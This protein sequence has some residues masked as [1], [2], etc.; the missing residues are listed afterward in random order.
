MASPSTTVASYVFP[1][2]TPLISL[3]LEGPNYITWS[4][5]IVPI[6]K[7]HDLMGIVDGTEPCPPQFLPPASDKEEPSLNPAYSLWVKKDQFILSWI[8]ITLAESV[9]STIYGLHTSHQVWKFLATKFAS[10]SR[11][12]IAQLRRQLQTLQQGSKSCTEYVTSAQLLAHQL[13]TVGKAVDDDEL[14]TYI[15]GGLNSSFNPFVVSLSLATRDSALTFEDFHTELLSVE[16]LIENQHHSVGP[17]T[18]VALLSHKPGPTSSHRKYRPPP[19]INTTPRGYSSRFS[20]QTGLLS[21]PPRA[22][23]RPLSS[24]RPSSNQS[25]PVFR[26]PCQICGKTSHRALDCFHRMD[27][28][29]QGRHPPAHLAAMVATNSVQPDDSTWYA[30]SG[31]NHHLTPALEKLHLHEPYTGSDTIAVGN[32]SGL[33]ITNTGS[34]SFTT[35]T[36]KL[37]MSRVFHC[38]QALANLLSINQFCKDNKCFFI[39]TDSHFF[40]KDNLTGLTLLEGKSEGGL[41]PINTSK[42]TLPKTRLFSALL[43]VKTSVRVWHSRLGHPSAS[44]VNDILNKHHL[45]FT[46]SLSNKEVCEPCHLAKS[47]Q[48]PFPSSTRVS[49]APLQLIHTDV[50][51]SPVVSLSGFRYY[52]IFID[53]FS[54]YSW[55]YPLSQKSDVFTS[56]MKF[57]SLVENQFS[58]Q[59]KQLQ[60]DG[61]GEF[62]SKQFTSLLETNGIFH[63]ISC[64]YTAQQNGLAERKH[65][66]VVEMGLSLLAQSGLPQSFWV[67]S[68]LTATFLINRLPTPLLNHCSP[69]FMLFQQIPDYS[70]LRSFGCLCFPLLRPY[71]SHKLMFRSKRCIFLGYGMNYKGYRCLDP[72]SNKVFITRHVVFDESTFPAKIPAPNHS[73]ATSSPVL[74]P[75]LIPADTIPPGLQANPTSSEPS[76]AS[77]SSVNPTSPSSPSHRVTPSPIPPLSPPSNAT[78]CSP[79]SNDSSSSMPLVTSPVIT[80]PALPSP[81]C[82]APTPPPPH[83][84]VTRSQTG[85]L[86]PK[87]FSSY[88]L[89]YSTRHPLRAL[90]SVVSPIEPSCYTQAVTSPEWRAA[91]GLEFDALLANG[92]WSLCPRPRN[93]NIVRNKWVYKVKRKQDGSVERF[94]ARLV[95]KG[96]DQ[97]SGVDFT[98]TFSPVIKSTTIRVVLALAVHFNW[99]IR[100]LDVSNAFLHGLLTEDVF[101]EQPR[102]FVDSAHPHHVCKLHKAIYGLKQAPR[103]WFTRLSQALFELGFHSSSV[104][105]SLFIYFH[106]SV[107]LYLLVYVDDILITGTDTTV[108]HS[109]IKQL[110]SVFAMKDLGDLGFFLGMQAHRDSTGLHIRQSKYIIDLLHNSSM[111][112]AKPYS[113]PSISGSKLSASTGD[114]LSDQ[115]TTTYRQV[116]GALQY[117]TITRPDIAYSVNQLCQFMHSPTSDHWVAAKRVLRYLKGSVDHG[118]LF[119]K[120]SLTLEAFC[121]SDWAGDPDSR[122][123]T[124]GFGVFLGPCLVSWCAK[125]Q[126][127]VARSSTEAEYRA[128]AVVTTEVY[129]LR[130][131][132]KDL[133]I[134]LHVPPTIWCD[135]IGA[136]A[137]ASNP[138][139]H[140]RTKHIEVDYHFVRE[141]VVNKDILVKFISTHDQL[142]DVFTKGLTSARFCFLRN[143]LKVV[144]VPPSACGGLLEYTPPIIPANHIDTLLL[145]KIPMRVPNKCYFTPSAHTA[146]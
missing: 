77:T 84:M 142:A 33:Q 32:D 120:G 58:T 66:H 31:A 109:I 124:T 86:R 70:L 92:T 23:S 38:P 112:G 134:S 98:E 119:R 39:L 53:D 101:M 8:N 81:V 22:P 1:N 4:F 34:F 25:S 127:V 11:T 6:L 42:V 30:D 91:M 46:G 87:D 141:K 117:C 59:I 9:L 106:S 85:S 105:T 129:W 136:L 68:F 19:R 48:L 115:D 144:S 63:R 10:P 55:L 104:D 5:T 145:D 114:P 76:L 15:I 146:P 47:K 28:A 121:D 3:K 45:P 16:Q 88:K 60:S 17:D 50:W 7:S 116:V 52:V 67:E 74:S 102:G 107:T 96:F 57:K 37:N 131:L 75:I 118:L 64:P 133:R 20:S 137:L 126:P 13:A 139:Y 18:S 40:I 49:T 80:P 83:T 113:A 24:N 61:G 89:F 123:S 73:P 143:K 62:L 79:T 41:Y 71:A 78:T 29:F 82:L 95:A 21:T 54:R 90:S 12:R 135:N 14:I 35:P 27:Y 94:K 56:F 99:C 130:M 93:Q 72:I 97:R 125:K 26:S 36:A 44:T 138:V 132:L 103:A 108:L 128:L 51:C 65:R 110:Q 2:L 100:Q 111:A 43:G 122:R 140:A 69:Y